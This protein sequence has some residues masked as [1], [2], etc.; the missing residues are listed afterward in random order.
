MLKKT[1]NIA[2][3]VRKLDL[4]LKSPRRA[5][6]IKGPPIPNI[7]WDMPPINSSLCLKILGNFMLSKKA[8]L[9][10][11]AISKI[12]KIID[13]IDELNLLNIKT[14][15]TTPITQSGNLGKKFLRLKCFKSEKAINVL[16]QVPI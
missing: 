10:E 1:K 4:L 9:M 7:P 13:K 11:S 3:V 6:T 14:P 15:I 2:I 8:I 12:P 16:E 5:L